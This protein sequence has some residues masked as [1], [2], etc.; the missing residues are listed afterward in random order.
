M[1][2]RIN[3]VIGGNED[4]IIIERDTIE[5]VREVAKVEM[6]KRGVDLSTCWSEEL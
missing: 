6:E 2:F 5:E 3:Y 4:S 1:R